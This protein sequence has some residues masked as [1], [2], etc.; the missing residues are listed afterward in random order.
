MAR[1]M[2]AT[3]TKVYRSCV[4]VAF[5]PGTLRW[6]PEGYTA[7]IINGPYGTIGAARNMVSHILNENN[8]ADSVEGWVESAEFVWNPAGAWPDK[9]MHPDTQSDYEDLR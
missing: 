8:H 2:A 3:D 4:A 9:D 5:K 6:H 7:T 1:R